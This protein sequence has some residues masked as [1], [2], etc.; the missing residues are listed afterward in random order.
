M[1]S[2]PPE[3]NDFNWS[4][5]RLS[6]IRRRAL[7]LAGFCLLTFCSTV[8]V[9]VITVGTVGLEQQGLMKRQFQLGGLLGGMFREVNG[10]KS[11]EIPSTAESVQQD[12]TTTSWMSSHT[13]EIPTLASH[14]L[15]SSKAITETTGS[16][17]SPGDPN[18]LL[19]IL[20]AAVKQA[21]KDSEKLPST[22]LNHLQKSVLSDLIAGQSFAAPLSADSSISLPFQTSRSNSMGIL[23]TPSVRI[24]GGLSAD[25]LT[26]RMHTARAIAEVPPSGFSTGG[27]SFLS[28]VSNIVAEISDIDPI[29]AAKLTDTVLDALHVNPSAIA[30]AV[31]KVANQASLP[32]AD[33]LPLIIPAVAQAMDQ[34]LPPIPSVSTL[35]MVETLDK[36]LQQG[37]T[38]INDLSRALEDITDPSLL[39]VV[40]QVAV[41][42]SDVADYLDKPLCA[43]DQ[44]LDGVSFDAVI[45]CASAEAA[46]LTSVGQLTTLAAPV[47]PGPTPHSTSGEIT[48]LAPP[49]PYS[50]K[51]AAESPTKTNSPSPANSGNGGSPASNNGSPAGTTPASPSCP[52][53]PSCDQCAP[54]ICSIQ[55]PEGPSAHQPP[56]PSKGPCP[57]RGFKC[58]ECLDGW[59]CPPQETPAQVA[60]C[61][62]GWPCY[63][64][65]EGWFCASTATPIPTPPPSSVAGSPSGIIST[66]GATTPTILPNT[67][68]L[69]DDW[70][71]LGCFQDAISRILLG[72]RPVDYLQGDMSTK[73]CVGHC[74]SSGYKFAG[75]ENGRECWCG[76]SIRD[77]AVRLPQSQC[78]KP[79]QGQPT[80]A[81]GGSWAIDVF[82]CSDKSDSH[83]DPPGKSTG[84]FM[85]RLLSS[86]KS[87]NRKAHH[88][89]F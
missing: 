59:F 58:A 55:G 28:E 73:E 7:V 12:S 19:D 80:E 72:A 49:S 71:Q 25:D 53:C 26:L 89:A 40:N 22:A 46:S 4:P 76:T 44:V 11:L 10:A 67:G 17:I 27:P 47:L 20:A 5:N 64:C 48:T 50:S 33:L 42:V 41:I 65:P 66:G 3:S 35:D 88:Q 87:N 86:F 2:P 1:A 70:T 78:G 62:V 82:L 29:A 8:F 34:P 13:V 30:S 24:L 18:K 21:I 83:Q 9:K 39:A 45:P 23:P 14:T 57:G 60:P 38:V 15:E 6:V 68:N 81:C 36:V 75:T 37:T 77:D 84:G 85:F 79:C 54:K 32:A 31:P 16:N 74:I 69:P 63:H 52:T 43:V 51:P 56:D 61:G